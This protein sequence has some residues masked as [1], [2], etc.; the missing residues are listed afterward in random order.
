MCITDI[1]SKKV[2]MIYIEL[3][4]VIILKCTPENLFNGNYT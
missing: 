4:T 1:S 3:V 2:H